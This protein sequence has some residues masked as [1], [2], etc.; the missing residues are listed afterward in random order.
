MTVNE[1]HLSGEFS[2]HAKK[3]PET[4]LTTVIHNIQIIIFRIYS[5]KKWKLF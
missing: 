5:C 1:N 2:P 4:Y 3:I